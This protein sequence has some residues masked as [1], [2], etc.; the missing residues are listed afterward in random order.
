MPSW[1]RFALTW[2]LA[3]ALPLQG[4]A[5]A[6]M[7]SCGPI[8]ERMTG[9]AAA[10]A[11]HMHHH[12]RA[13]MHAHSPIHSDDRSAASD[14]SDM[15]HG[16]AHHDFDKLSKFKCSACSVC[17]TAAALPATIVSFDATPVAHSVDQALPA[18]AVVFLTAGPERPPR[19]IFA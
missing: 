16:A 7:L 11:P 14:A 18:T 10:A 9:A 19:P 5:A 4:W 15:E 8:D 17:C 2:L 6:S 12:G 1:L 13:A 3:I